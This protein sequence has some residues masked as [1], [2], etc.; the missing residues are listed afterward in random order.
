MAVSRTRRVFGAVVI[1]I[2]AI[3]FIFSI[4]TTFG[5]TY[6]LQENYLSVTLVPISGA[7]VM[8]GGL[9]AGLWG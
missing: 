2:G 9:I 5:L 8:V 7:V 6:S 4:L 3:G 1:A